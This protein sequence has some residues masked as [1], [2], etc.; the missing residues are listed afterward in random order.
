M[1]EVPVILNIPPKLIPI[2]TKIN[3]YH[4]FLIDGGRASGKS[5]TIARLI[6]W[7]CEQK[8]LRVVGGRETQTSIEESVYT[9]FADLIRQYKLNF[10]VGASKIDH[11]VTGSALRFR[12]FREQGAIN[13][14]GLEGVDI[15]WI[16]ESQAISKSTLDVIIP[17]IRKENSKIIFSMNRHI[18]TDPVYVAMAGRTDCLHIHQ[19]YLDNPFCPQKMI[20]EADI[21]KATD[22]DSYNHIWLGRPL[23]KSD[24]SL[25]STDEVY[26]SPKL[27]F[28]VPGAKK[29]VMGVDVARYGEDETVFSIIES[30]NVNQWCHIFQDTWK[31]KSLTECVGKIIELKRI[32]NIDLIVVDDSGVGG[33]VT[34][35]LMEG[36]YPVRAYNGAEKAINPL[37]L[38][39]RAE[40]YFHLKTMFGEKTIKILAD[41]GLYEQ[42]LG[43]RYKYMSQGGRKAIISKD[44]MR[45]D[46]LKSPDRADALAMACYFK[47]DVLN[48]DN[49]RESSWPTSYKMEETFA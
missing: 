9:I 35:M 47:D 12:G 6:L 40:A 45:K 48:E 30:Y 19:D 22:I 17:T 44:E 4:Y 18:E 38:N 27:N 28:I 34:D 33:G 42:L 36:N 11:P 21:C 16:D 7:L 13:I 32:W 41:V 8:P 5:Q 2:I 39:K 24:D 31:N 37:Y 25:F 46:G 26:G 23:K 29:R 15:L 3:D 1:I 49:T 43:I 14:K 20:E 10:K